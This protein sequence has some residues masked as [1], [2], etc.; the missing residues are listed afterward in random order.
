MSLS[1]GS[2]PANWKRTNI[3]PVI[4]KSDPTLTENYT[5]ISLLCIVCK[6]MER[7][8]FNHCYSHLSSFLQELQHGFQP[9]KSRETQLLEVYHDI[10]YKLANGQEVDAIHFDL[11]KAFDKVAHRLLLSKLQVRGISSPVLLWFSSYFS[12]RYQRVVVDAIS[13]DWLPVTSGVP[14]GSILGPLLF[15]VFI[16]DISCSITHESK[17]GLFADDSKLYR[18]IVSNRCASLLQADLDNSNT[19]CD[20]NGMSFSTNKWKVLHKSKRT[21]R[22]REKHTYHL[23]GQTLDSPPDTKDLGLIVTTPL[24]WTT[25]I[26]ETCS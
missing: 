26:E 13:S 22:E 7:C 6:V 17:L 8:A 21:P 12:D 20:N 16:N 3:A 19:W 18:A 1:T 11:S 9:G 14:Q 10:L 5:P 23:D 25:H 15:L 2:F 24:S 4:K